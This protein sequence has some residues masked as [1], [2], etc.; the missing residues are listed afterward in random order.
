MFLCAQEYSKWWVKDN[1][2]LATQDF[3][4]VVGSI[5]HGVLLL[6]NPIINT[7]EHHLSNHFSNSLSHE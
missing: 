4:L 5:H 7:I 3:A 6:Q 2:S 1:A